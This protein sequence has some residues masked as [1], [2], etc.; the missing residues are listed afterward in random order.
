[1]T[2]RNFQ[3][4]HSGN[5][6]IQ[7]VRRII[8]L[9]AQGHRVPL[10][11][12]T[13][14]DLGSF[15]EDAICREAA[16]RSSSAGGVDYTFGSIRTSSIHQRPPARPINCETFGQGE[17]EG[18]PADS[19]GADSG[20]LETK[21]IKYPKTSSNYVGNLL[22]KY[23]HPEKLAKKKKSAKPSKPGRSKTLPP[24]VLVG[25]PALE[26]TINEEIID[27]LARPEAYEA[28]GIDPFPTPKL[29]VGP[30]G[31]G[32]SWCA[33]HL[34][35]HLHT[36]LGYKI[37]RINSETIASPY[38]HSS[39]RLLSEI[40]ASA[41]KAK[42]GAVVLCDEA[43]SWMMNRERYGRHN[44]HRIEETDEML[45]QVETAA[46][47]RIIFV[48]SSNYSSKEGLIDH[49][50][51][52]PGRLEVIELEMP[53]RD[54][55][56]ALLL[57]LLSTMP[58]SPDLSIANAVSLLEG[59]SLALTDYAVKSSAFKAIRAGKPEIDQEALDLALSELPD[60]DEIK[61]NPIGFVGNSK[62]R[63]Q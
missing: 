41:A 11:Q 8:D 63:D 23:R 3:A 59:R 18:D 21:P 10:D 33:N 50:M 24:F 30:A 22:F 43:E 28:F 34:A 55:V 44:G 35:E 26:K 6:S 14:N 42:H 54:E 39:P 62:S 51:L 60:H 47:R 61:R 48:A 15:E 31:C 46:S 19:E 27:R 36:H 25:R 49:A 16:L 1:M 53:K 5:S 17:T 57:H 40:M 4:M 12:P 20:D 32:K 37:L 38:I 7:K 13:S 9:A 45:R 56:Q 2:S 29:L 58:T 52:R